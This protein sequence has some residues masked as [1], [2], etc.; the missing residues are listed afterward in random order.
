MPTLSP[1]QILRNLE[2]TIRHIY[3]RPSMWGDSEGVEA[4]LWCI[5]WCWAMA[6][7]REQEFRDLHGEQL[8]EH[9]TSFSLV[10]TYR[11]R[12]PAPVDDEVRQF[13]LDTWGCITKR[14]G[15]DLSESPTPDG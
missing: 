9:H 8:Q 11:D 10:R 5:H 3:R 1:E 4:S 12:H 15:I 14:L 2:D 6:Q 7:M 13:V